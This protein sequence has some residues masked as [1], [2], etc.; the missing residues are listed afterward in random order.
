MARVSD[1]LARRSS[2]T[3]VGRSSELAAMLACL[4]PQG[5]LV[6]YLHGIGGIGKSALLDAFCNDARKRQATVVR[7]DC[8]AVE[9]TERGVLQ[10]LRSALGATAATVPKLASRLARIGGRVVITLDTYEVFRLMDTWLRQVFVPAL[11][12]HVR[13]VIAER[14]APAAPW[15]AAPGW[16]GLFRSVPL[17]ALDQSASIELLHHL[18]VQ[19]DDAQRVNRFARGHPLSLILAASA[20]HER[21]DL[22]LEEGTIPAVVE[23]LTRTYLADVS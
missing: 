7:I 3:F 17:G 12:D 2:D 11:P 19:A 22:D 18:G 10:E 9:P 5:P 20:L 8:R 13:V 4:E 6:L 16:R 15:H 23:E 14:E 1:L 21:P